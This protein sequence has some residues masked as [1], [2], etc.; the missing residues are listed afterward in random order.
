MLL[1]AT[2]PKQSAGDVAGVLKVEGYVR[3]LRHLSR[4]QVEFMIDEA[5]RRCR[6]LPAPAEMLAIADDWRRGDEPVQVRAKAQAMAQRE[7]QARMDESFAALQCGELDD[8]A[9]SA[10]PE[11]WQQIAETRG[12][13]TI[14]DGSCRI[15]SSAIW[16]PTA[17]MPPAEA[18]AGAAAAF[19]TKRDATGVAA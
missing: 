4:P 11:R 1:M 12:L 8:A 10:W 3:S 6:W 17:A 9:V 13:I 7:H 2:L 15:R 14:E 16:R 5:L 19:P 18:L